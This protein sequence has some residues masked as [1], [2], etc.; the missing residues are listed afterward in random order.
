M[1]ELQADNE[2]LLLESEQL[3]T[4]KRAPAAVVKHASRSRSR[5]V[6]AKDEEASA[7]VAREEAEDECTFSFVTAAAV[8]ESTGT[9]LPACQELAKQEGALVQHTLSMGEAYRNKYRGK[10]LAIS[11]RWETP[12]QPDPEGEQLKAVKEYLM[13]NPEV[14]LVWYDYW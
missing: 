10:W 6:V 2:R 7:R 11:H 8:L 14:E 5:S 9:A 4:A 12:S 13:K 1:A 3:R